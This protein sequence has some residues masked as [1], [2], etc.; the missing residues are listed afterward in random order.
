MMAE[1]ATSL[2]VACSVFAGL[3][4]LLPFCLKG[5]ILKKYKM[6][7]GG[8]FTVNESADRMQKLVLTRLIHL[9]NC[10]VGGFLLSLALVKMYPD[11]MEA[12]KVYLEQK[13]KAGTDSKELAEQQFS[14]RFPL[15][16]SIMFMG[17]MLKVVLQHCIAKRDPKFDYERDKVSSDGSIK[18]S[19]NVPSSN[20]GELVT[21]R[22]D[23]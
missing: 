20:V 2:V 14:Q 9:A 23:V 11:I 13:D 21:Q 15:I 6:A 1:H 18:G 22:S 3:F 8:A 19:L 10:F 4:L 7:Q 16:L 17:F 5:R 12:Y